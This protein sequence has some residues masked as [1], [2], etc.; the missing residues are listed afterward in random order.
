MGISRRTL[1]RST[2]AVA[3]TS[4]FAAQA[5]RQASP[6]S[7]A[8]GPG[9]VVGKITVGYQGWFAC[10]GDGAPINGWWHWS[11]NWSQPPSPSNNN[12]KAWPDMG[13]YPNKYQTA[14]ANLNNGQPA[15]L[16]SSY[17]Q[18]T[19]NA[20]FMSMQQNNLDT[21]ALQRFNPNTAEG[22][23]RDAVAQRV[24]TAAETYGRKFYIMY[25]ATGWTNMST[26]M[27]ADWTNKMS[28]HTASPA[29]ARQ[30]GKPVVGIWGFGFNDANHPWDPATC[31]SV[32]QWFQSQGCYVMGGVPR[33]WRT[34]TGG[35]RSGFLGTY[36]AF[37]MISPWMVG[38]IGTIADV[39]NVYTQYTVGDVADCNSNGI[40]YQ[41]CVLPGD[42][43][44][45]QRVHGDFMWAQFYNMVRAGVQGIYISMF[46]EYGE[47]NQIAKTAATQAAVPSNSGLLSLDED[48]T[49]CSA[50]Y[51]LRLTGDGGKMLKGQIALTSTRPTPPVVGGDTTPPTAPGNLQVTGNTDTTVSLS[52]SASTDNV[53]V[54]GYNVQRVN[55]STSTVLGSTTATSFTVSG[56]TASTSYTF[57]VTAYDAA[58]NVSQ[59]SNTVTVTTSA[60]SGNTD[61]A[62]H[63]PTSAS[64]TQSG[65][66]S[67][68]AV[69]GD[70]NTY[71]ESTNNAFPQWFQV[72]LG[73]S[74]AIG[75][76]TMTL[77]AS[78]GARTQTIT[79]QGSAD[80][81][82]YT[83]IVGSAGYTF[84]PNTGNSVSVTLP[85]T[86]TRYLKLTFTANTGWPA[87]QLS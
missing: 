54:A 12:V 37:N 23:T 30:N 43:S 26:E 81:S 49:A 29:Y 55:G 67:S 5:V 21:A 51:Y 15:T 16:F 31:L 83:T 58:G 17:D 28:A 62:L 42:L 10:I 11:N 72:D 76:L 33:E 71:W 85:S 36:H 70:Q 14:Y 19:V 77:P 84:N 13:D 39:N 48:G 41:P 74:K 1:L 9:D 45:R 80:G 64:G 60:P 65:Y 87:G 22:P 34:G 3:A 73:S 57:D 78:W 63:Q 47:G 75:S 6:A 24:R 82:N 53:G 44:G 25:D 2:A 66:P 4:G 8:S 18:S 61:L 69:D 50:D 32:I 20:H 56:L 59:A 38:A 79:I 46:D 27:P 86:T 52:W 40:D 7:A 35:S 68:N